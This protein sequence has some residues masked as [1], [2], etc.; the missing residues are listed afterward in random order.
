MLCAQC[1]SFC[2]ST[3]MAAM[4]QCICRPHRRMVANRVGQIFCCRSKLKALASHFHMPAIE[5]YNNLRSNVHIL[6]LDIEST[7]A[8]KL[9]FL[10]GALLE[11]ELQAN[12]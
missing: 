3:A 2:N 9:N 4:L 7:I 12:S 5:L 11:G 10:I 1:S 8:P 6:Q